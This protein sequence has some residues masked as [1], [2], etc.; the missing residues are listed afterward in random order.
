[1]QLVVIFL[2]FMFMRPLLTSPWF[3]IFIVFSCIFP[4]TGGQIFGILLFIGLPLY[5]IFKD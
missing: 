3:W 2:V 1:M 5:L 4:Y